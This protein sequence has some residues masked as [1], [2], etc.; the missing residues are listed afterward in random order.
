MTALVVILLYSQV[1][2]LI[3]G[4]SSSL[5]RSEDSLKPLKLVF[6][7]VPKLIS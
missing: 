6:D 4:V 3:V 7:V 1:S 2:V 5:P